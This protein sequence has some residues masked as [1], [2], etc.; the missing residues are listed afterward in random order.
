M[1]ENNN[2]EIPTTD[3]SEVDEPDE[4]TLEPYLDLELQ[5]GIGYH[6][7]EATEMDTE[8]PDLSSDDEPNVAEEI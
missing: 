2:E 5:D 7:V 3:E 8:R 6:D 1:S 4:E